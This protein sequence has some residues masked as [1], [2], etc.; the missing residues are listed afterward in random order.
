MICEYLFISALTSWSPLSSRVFFP[1]AMGRNGFARTV[2]LDISD[3]PSSMVRGDIVSQFV[4]EFSGY[5]IDSIQFMPGSRLFV[6]FQH[7]N[8]KAFVEESE[9]VW[10]GSVSCRVLGGGPRLQT[11][12]I[13]HYPYEAESGPLEKALGA[14]GD[15]D[16]VSFQH[17]PDLNA[18]AT[19]VRLVRMVRRA[20]IPRNLD[21]G[22][23]LCRVWYRGIPIECDICGKDHVARDCPL[24]GKCRKC[25]QPGHF[26]RDCRNP[27]DAWGTAGARTFGESA[28]P[29]GDP[30]PAEAV[31][32]SASVQPVPASGPSALSSD[33]GVAPMDADPA[34]SQQSQSILADPDPACHLISNWGDMVI[35][36][37]RAKEPQ[38]DIVLS[39]TSNSK[40]IACQPIAGKTSTGQVLASNMAIVDSVCNQ[41]SVKT[42]PNACSAVSS[43]KPK[44]SKVKGK[45]H[46]GTSSNAT[47]E[48]QFSDGELVDEGFELAPEVSQICSE[49]DAVLSDLEDGQAVNTPLFS[50]GEGLVSDDPSACSP[51]PS[52][53]LSQPD[54]SIDSSSSDSVVVSRG[55]SSRRTTPVSEEALSRART[56]SRSSQDRSVSAQHKLP[57]YTPSVPNWKS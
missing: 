27:P 36:N 19:G 5:D 35:D 51:S 17:Y 10:V 52:P 3:F 30:T 44:A 13:F 6:T 39:E 1:S 8:S 28:A 14:Y 21:I 49:S 12:N 53:V 34:D 20:R 24:K 47:S 25:R 38:S 33:A 57:A 43:A 42:K 48:L 29:S 4:A 16:S 11:V 9:S 31:S 2:V 18:I 37:V 22:G 56:R 41:S 55:R 54:L 46:A 45:L 40:L 26:S 7:P 50:S 15:V 32:A 23:Q